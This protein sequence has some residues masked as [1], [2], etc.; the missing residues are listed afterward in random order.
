MI[1]SRT[2]IGPTQP[3]GY[4]SRSTCVD[5]ILV[6]ISDGVMALGFVALI[7]FDL[8]P[9]SD[10]DDVGT[11]TPGAELAPSFTIVIGFEGCAGAQV[12]HL[13]VLREITVET[14]VLEVGIRVIDNGWTPCFERDFDGILVVI[15]DGVMDLGFVALIEFDLTPISDVEVVGTVTPGAELFVCLFV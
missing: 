9:I 2:F 5:G 12:K 6:V 8:T 7:E 15:S 13:G 10:V 14:M 1:S 11:V 3:W 4:T